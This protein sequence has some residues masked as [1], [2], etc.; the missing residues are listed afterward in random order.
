MLKYLFR[1]ADIYNKKDNRC[2]KV[3]MPIQARFKHREG[4]EIRFFFSEPA[5][6]I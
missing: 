4:N 5:F 2:E 3:N 1:G 6:M